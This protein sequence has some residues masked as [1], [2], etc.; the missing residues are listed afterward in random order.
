[1]TEDSFR[2]S[3]ERVGKLRELLQDPVL[4][5]AVVCLRD[6]RPSGDTADHAEPVA[7]VRLLSR[8]SGYDSCID[9]FLTLA[10]P[11]PIEKPDEQPNFGVD[12]SKFGTSK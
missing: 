3:A 11:L 12:M 2:S 1:M 9:L 4:A 7:S 5:A 8:Q 6:M 10:E